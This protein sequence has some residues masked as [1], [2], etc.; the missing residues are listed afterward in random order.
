MAQDWSNAGRQ[1]DDLA[2][3]IGRRGE[4]AAL[5]ELDRALA[6][7]RET[8]FPLDAI[9][10]AQ[11]EQQVGFSLRRAKDG[12][13]F[14]SIYGRILRDE[15]CKPGGDLHKL[16]TAGIQTSAGAILGVLV[17][18]LGPPGAAIGVLV[19]IAAL[20]ASRGVDAFCEFT[21]SPQPTR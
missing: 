18:A 4:Q 8:G 19:P 11:A 10:P 7:Y 1:A 21:R 13:S 2:R 17:S 15:L 20:I 14:W 3:V 6:E 5:R 9:V 12:K 16:A